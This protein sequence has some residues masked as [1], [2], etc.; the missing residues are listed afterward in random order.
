FFSAMWAFALSFIEP[1]RAWLWWLLMAAWAPLCALT[2]VLSAEPNGWPWCP[3]GVVGPWTIAWTVVGVAFAFAVAGALVGAVLEFALRTGPWRDIPWLRYVK[4][5]LGWAGSALAV[6]LVLYTTLAIASPLQP[7]GINQPYC[8]DEFCFRTTAVKRAKTIGKGVQQVAAHGTFYIVEAKMEAPWWGRFWW[9][10]DAVYVLTRDDR[11]YEHSAQ[12]QRVI[13]ELAGRSSACHEI[14]GAA[15]TETIV[16]DLP[17]DAI[18]PRLL[19][20]DTLGF[21]GFMGAMRIGHAHVNPAFNLR[22]D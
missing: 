14:L 4:P 10:P 16:F 7:Y 1:R 3:H 15:E 18:Q 11:R 6:L 22:F 17:D 5:A 12:G 9:S 13:D 21:E 2:G 20:R 8:W 19:V